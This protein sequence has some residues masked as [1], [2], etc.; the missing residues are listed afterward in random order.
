MKKLLLILL[1]LPMIGFGQL[2]KGFEIGILFGT[3]L[4]YGNG[5]AADNQWHTLENDSTTINIQRKPHYTTIQ[6][7]I[8]KYHFNK[9]LSINLD[10]NYHI[11]GYKDYIEI[12][13]TN[14]LTNT[15]P[16]D[17]AILINAGSFT[18]YEKRYYIS[19]PLSFAYSFSS[20]PT[21]KIKA[22]SYNAFLIMRKKGSTK[23]QGLNNYNRFDFGGILGVELSYPIN[24]KISLLFDCTA[25][26]GVSQFLKGTSYWNPP[27]DK[28][29][30]SRAAF[31]LTYKL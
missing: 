3:S 13:E 8:T 9:H 31:G 5:T 27:D 1:C 14:G 18:D 20:K 15:P 4:S 26:Y 29:R 11:T 2:D 25:Y 23:V 6:G 24:D 19:L 17:P 21:Y 22:G 16:G 10:I 28:N 12:S 7:I 30:M